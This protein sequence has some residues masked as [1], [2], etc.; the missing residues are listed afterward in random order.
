MNLPNI[1]DFPEY[2]IKLP[3]TKQYLKFRPFKAKEQVNL[4][5]IKDSKDV[6][7]IFDTVKDTLGKCITNNVDLD[8]LPLADFEYFILKVREKSVGEE[9][10]IR[11]RCENP[12]GMKDITDDEGN[13][14]RRE[15][16]I[17]NGLTDVK[18]NFGKA[19]LTGKVPDPIVNLTPT[20]AVE[21]R[22]IPFDVAKHFNPNESNDDKASDDEIKR[23]NES[24]IDMVSSIIVKIY[25]NEDV[26]ETSNYTKEQLAEWVSNLTSD[27]FGK[28]TAWIASYPSLVLDINFTCSKCG[29]E[30]KFPLKNLSDFFG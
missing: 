26:Y 17:C 2:K 1:N 29:K 20:V 27:Q 4:L 24:L 25:V 7:V 23:I 30:H 14:I 19:K 13:I 16:E 18:V 22:G 3:C 5:L 8:S 28:I 15:P 9:E 21:L 10:N 12:I 11:F 6:D